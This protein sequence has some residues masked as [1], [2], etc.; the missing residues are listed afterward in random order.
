VFI[1]SQITEYKV[2]GL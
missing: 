1:S 2:I